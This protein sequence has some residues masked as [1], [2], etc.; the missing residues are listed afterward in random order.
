LR[1]ITTSEDLRL[2]LI[3]NRFNWLKDG[4]N[5]SSHYRFYE[6]GLYDSSTSSKT[7]GSWFVENYNT[8]KFINQY[9]TKY[10]LE[11]TD[12]FG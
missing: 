6:N 11:F 12:D 4:V 1:P 10:I 2:H 5:I 7:K 3:S 8:V 9:D